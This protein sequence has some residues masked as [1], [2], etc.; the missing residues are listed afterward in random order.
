MQ[1]LAI[2][3]LLQGPQ[4]LRVCT[5]RLV[6]LAPGQPQARNH[7]AMRQVSE[8][9]PPGAP[10]A[11]AVRRVSESTL[12][13]LPLDLAGATAKAVDFVRHRV[14]MGDRLHEQ[15]GFSDLVDLAV[16]GSMVGS[17]LIESTVQP[18]TVIKKETQAP[19]PVAAPEQPAPTPDWTFPPPADWLAR[20]KP[21]AGEA[22]AVARIVARLAP[23]VWRALSAGRRAR[24][25][26]RVGER[27]DAARQQQAAQQS[28]YALAPRLV[29]LLESGNDLLDYCLAWSLA[30]LGDPGTAQALQ[31]LAQH[32]RSATTRDLAV[33]AHLWLLAR[34]DMEAARAALAADCAARQQV[35][36]ELGALAHSPLA[37]G[38]T[39]ALPAQDERDAAARALLRAEC[40]ALIDTT[41][42]AALREALAQVRFAPQVF[43]AVRQIHK[44]A[45]MRH[46]WPLLAT[47]HA[48][49]EADAPAPGVS[50][51]SRAPELGQV[52]YQ[53]PKTGE[54][55]ARWSPKAQAVLVYRR[56]TRDYFLARGLRTVRRLAEVG[57]TQAPQA[58][59]A[60]LLQL[61]THR[62]PAGTRHRDGVIAQGHGWAAAADLLLRGE[63]AWCSAGHRL[64]RSTRYPALSGDALPDR[65]PDGP[66]P[67]WDAQPQAVLH[68]LRH[69]GNR[70]VQWVMARAMRDHMAWLAELPASVACEL[71]ASRFAHTAQLGLDVARAHLAKAGTLDEHLPWWL[72][73]ARSAHAPATELL[74]Q[75]LGADMARIAQ[76]PTLVAA[77]LFSPAASLRMM[78]YSVT[79]LSD[80]TKSADTASILNEVLILLPELDEQ[81][82]AAEDVAAG[83]RQWLSGPWAAHAGDVP[84]APLLALLQDPALPV[85]QVASTWVALHPEATAHLPPDALRALLTADDDARRAC[86]VRLLAGLPARVLAEQADL[87]WAESQSPAADMRAAVYPA[88]AR[89]AQAASGADTAPGPGGQGVPV[90]AADLPAIRAACEQLAQRLH[91]SLFRAE[92]AEGVHTDTLALLA[93]PL[94]P[95]TPRPDGAAIWRAL[96]AQ[97]GGAQR[98]GAA[99]LPQLPD[100]ALSLRQWAT[101]GRHADVAVRERA[102]ASIERLLSPLEATTPEQADVLLPL[103]DSLFGDAQAW[104]R[105][106]FSRH[107][108]EA[109][110][111]T[112]LLIRWVDHPQAWVQALGR[113]RLMRRMSAVD[114]DLCLER[115]AQHP[116][117]AVQAFVTNWLLALPDEPAPQRAA[118]LARLRPYFLTVLSQVHRGRVGKTRVQAFLR[119]Q[120]E[121]PETAAVVAEIYARQVVGA[122]RLDQLHYMAGLRDIAAR[123]PGLPLPF[124]Q[125]Q[126]PEQRAGR[127][128]AE[129]V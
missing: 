55:Q 72:A 12:T 110:L 41:V 18:D 67:L 29:A 48:R 27:F 86:G 32:A 111:S 120:I 31:T 85:V 115:L 68:L 112:E 47:L 37:L 123:H 98:H 84:A 80:K 88:I 4:G 117:V 45:E 87:L 122:G 1:T 9:A 91:A 116:S 28:L 39:P 23:D 57:S 20:R 71:L 26:W 53:H 19:G 16:D 2:A 65:R 77:L 64:R 106:L 107:L 44:R 89:L 108:P 118:R 7:V 79:P 129:H 92:P 17:Q 69:S 105:E 104:T 51:E 21:P 70:L 59:V 113:Q 11:G 90:P 35:L 103:A 81:H 83:L 63:P 60:L 128:A 58:A 99:H 126:P 74:A 30:R 6:A 78:G 75:S 56:T 73:L 62:P 114:A 34:H 14:A 10:D 13:P 50:P 36:D 42:H 52:L 3:T 109:A 22:D 127:Q 5:V 119:S 93:G 8:L 15:S 96:H 66:L 54:L 125:W 33:H 38:A 49:F 43:A 40:L 121:A 97:S 61:P 46:D 24:L 82:P 25:V 94:A 124:M 100:D 102:M 76:L 95:F 101:L